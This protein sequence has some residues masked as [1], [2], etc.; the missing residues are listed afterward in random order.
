MKNLC[1]LDNIVVCALYMM[2]NIFELYIL[3][4]MHILLFPNINIPICFYITRLYINP[5]ILP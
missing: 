2:Y 5:I 4:L 1:F 3:F